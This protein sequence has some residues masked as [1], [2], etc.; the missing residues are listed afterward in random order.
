MNQ[1]SHS[2]AD[3]QKKKNLIKKDPCTSKF[4]AALFIIAKI[5]KPPKCPSTDKWIKMW[6]YMYTME[7]YS[8]I[9]RMEFCHLQ[10]HDGL[11]GH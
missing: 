4:I 10:Q 6:L 7:Y 5:W 9:T 1:Q 2:V 8:A 11:G 3:I